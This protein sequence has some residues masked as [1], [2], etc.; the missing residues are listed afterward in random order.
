MAVSGDPPAPPSSRPM[1]TEVT[2]SSP[3]GLWG[4]DRP[5]DGAPAAGR[6]CGREGPLLR[7]IRVGHRAGSAPRC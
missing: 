7:L 5:A 1:L 2:P 4:V 3:V 6:A